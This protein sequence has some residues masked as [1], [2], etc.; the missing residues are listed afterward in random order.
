MFSGIRIGELCALKWSDIDEIQ[1]TINVSKTLQRISIK[2][3]DLTTESKIIITTP[4]SNKSIRNIPLHSELISR[5]TENIRLTGY[6]L[7]NSDIPLEPREI[8]YYYSSILKKLSIE[9]KSFHSLRHTF[10]T[11]LIKN[12]NDFKTVSELLGHSSISTTLDIYT[13]TSEE[14]KINCI[15]KY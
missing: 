1:K 15:N 10:A 4:K 6:I 13:Y 2:N 12:T 11:R 7:T 14:T 9:H 3:P 5:T 8:R